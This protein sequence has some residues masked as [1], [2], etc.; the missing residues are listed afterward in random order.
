MPGKKRN[1]KALE[2]L[3]EPQYHS[4]AAMVKV[5]ISTEGVAPADLNTLKT[6]FDAGGSVADLVDRV[7]IAKVKWCFDKN[8]SKIH[9][10]VCAELAPVLDAL[11]RAMCL[12]VRSNGDSLRKVATT[13][14]Y[15]SS[16]ISLPRL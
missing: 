4:W 12:V 15:R 1:Y 9:F 11:L 16:S 8:M 10:A 13:E 6:H 5:A 14:S 7:F 2:E 3:G